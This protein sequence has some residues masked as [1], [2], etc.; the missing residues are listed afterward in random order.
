MKKI[1]MIPSIIM[2]LL[3]L[4]LKGKKVVKENK[5]LKYPIQSIFFSFNMQCLRE[6]VIWVAGAYGDLGA[7]LFDAVSL[8]KSRRR[9]KNKTTFK[10]EQKVFSTQLHM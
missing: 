1:E 6:L 7:F 9:N 4:M 2:G 8:Y 3:S 10:F 5:N